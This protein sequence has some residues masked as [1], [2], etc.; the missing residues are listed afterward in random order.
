MISG[1]RFSLGNTLGSLYPALR[2]ECLSGLVSLQQ[3]VRI[4]IVT[5]LRPAEAKLQEGLIQSDDFSSPSS[6]I[7]KE[8]DTEG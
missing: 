2:V 5:H 4:G 6:L 1:F 8:V 7:T 3:L